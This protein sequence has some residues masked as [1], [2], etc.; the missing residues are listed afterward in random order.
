MNEN[1]AKKIFKKGQAENFLKIHKPE[2]FGKRTDRCKKII[3]LGNDLYS[4]ICSIDIN[5]IKEYVREYSITE[6]KYSDIHKDPDY[7]RTLI[8]ETNID[9]KH[10]PCHPEQFS[11]SV[12]KPLIRNFISKKMNPDDIEK[13]IEEKI[14]PKLENHVRERINQQTKADLSEYLILM[15]CKNIIPT[16]KQTKGTDMYLVKD[17][18]SVED[19]DI[20]TTRSIWGIED[21]KEAIKALYENQGKDRFS[22]DTR[23]YIYLSDKEL[24]DPENIVKQLNELYEIE[25]IYDKKN[26]RVDGCRLVI[27]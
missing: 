17:D 8:N 3:Y 23:L 12:V 11:E 15:N 10:S 2:L 13:Y 16:L 21:K 6:G 5:T 26:Y 18:G 4:D 14:K 20:K 22:D 19:L 27:I 1:I 24:C 7:S 25:F 9:K